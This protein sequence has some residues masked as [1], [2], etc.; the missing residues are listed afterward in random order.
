MKKKQAI[1]LAEGSAGDREVSAVLRE[2]GYKEE[3]IQRVLKEQQGSMKL[4]ELEAGSDQASHPLENP[5]RRSPVM[6]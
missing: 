5:A 4:D 1:I 6:M 3:E 2:W